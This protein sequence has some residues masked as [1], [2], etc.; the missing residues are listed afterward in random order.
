MRNLLLHNICK[1]AAGLGWTRLCW[2][3]GSSR[4]ATRT[5]AILLVHERGTARPRLVARL[6][7]QVVRT[8]AAT[9]ATTTP[10][11]G[12]FYPPMPYAPSPPTNGMAIASMVL[13][14]LWI[15]WVG[16]I[17]ALIF[18][19]IALRQI[20]ELG[21]SGRGMAITGVV[22]GWVGIG[23]LAV[24][25]VIVAVINSHPTTTQV[26]TPGWL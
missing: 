25:I 17:L 15:Y 3:R 9:I 10:T 26:V 20:R 16:S 12:M 11:E 6:R 8:R 18:G 13:G 7:R 5:A 2:S 1:L 22:L 19:Y 21:E 24:V 4:R 23:T 14:I